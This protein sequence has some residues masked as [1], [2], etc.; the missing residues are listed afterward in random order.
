M[1]KTF[2][3][4]KNKVRN[5]QLRMKPRQGSSKK[6]VASMDIIVKRHVGDLIVLLPVEEREDVDQSVTEE[7]KDVDRSVTEEHEDV[8]QSVTEHQE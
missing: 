5:V 4:N 6:Y 1:N 2:P 3:D 7:R 8:D